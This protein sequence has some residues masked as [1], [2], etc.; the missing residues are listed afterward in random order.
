MSLIS[1]TARFNMVAGLLL[2]IWKRLPS[3]LTR[4]YRLQTDCGERIIGRKVSAAWVA[5]ALDGTSNLTPDAAFSALMHGK[6][7]LDLAES[8]Q[9]APRARDGCTSHRVDRLHREQCG[10]DSAPMGYSLRSSRGSYACSSQPTT[11][12]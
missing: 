7:V 11:A 1:P 2:P 8:F 10:I 9:T 3:E 4:V 12:A 5:A 6:T